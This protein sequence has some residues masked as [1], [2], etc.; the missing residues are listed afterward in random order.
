MAT[1]KKAATPTPPATNGRTRPVLNL[2]DIFA[3][4]VLFEVG[5]RTHE[6]RR[7]SALTLRDQHW[8]NAH[9]RRMDE[10]SKTPKMTREREA[11]YERVVREM[12]PRISSMTEDE[13]APLALELCEGVVAAFFTERLIAQSRLTEAIGRSLG[14]NLT[15]ASSSLASIDSGPNSEQVNG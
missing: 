4:A 3:P 14:L 5:G 2:D 6:L 1:R 13:T 11:E 12:L 15:G 7:F 9:Y 8:L 10:I